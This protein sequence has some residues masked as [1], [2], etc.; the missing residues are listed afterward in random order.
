MPE[1]IK[2]LK[3]SLLSCS[4]LSAQRGWLAEEDAGELFMS[5]GLIMK[6]RGKKE[7]SGQ[8]QSGLNIKC[9]SESEEEH[10][11]TELLMHAVISADRVRL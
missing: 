9:Q 2:A 4:Y 8:A 1:G 6:V 7:H 5:V 3:N 10:G 11:T